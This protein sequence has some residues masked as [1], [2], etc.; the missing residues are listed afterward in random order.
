[1]NTILPYKDMLFK[2]SFNFADGDAIY[3]ISIHGIITLLLPREK[4]RNIG[5]LAKSRDGILE[6]FV[7]RNPDVHLFTKLNAY[8]VNHKIME[9]FDPDTI[10]F[11]IVNKTNAKESDIRVVDRDTYK[12]QSQFLYF[13]K[14]NFELQR[15]IGLEHLRPLKPKTTA[16]SI[17]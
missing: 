1:M 6:Y 8:G 15:F 11:L 7:T 2:E 10:V 16:K 14:Q 5:F 12:Q 13:K 17:I 4:P 3:T 9:V